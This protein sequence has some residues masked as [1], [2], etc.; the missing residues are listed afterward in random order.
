MA[1]DCGFEDRGV[2]VIDLLPFCDELEKF[3]KYV[4]NVRDLNFLTYEYPE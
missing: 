4:G 1:E 3:I 2:S